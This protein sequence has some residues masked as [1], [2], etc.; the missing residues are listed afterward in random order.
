MLGAAAK[1]AKTALLE[2]PS[3]VTVAKAV[4]TEA[5]LQGMREAHLR[6]SVALAQTLHWL[7]TQVPTRR[8][9]TCTETLAG[10]LID[11]QFTSRMMH[12]AAVQRLC[13]DCEY[14]NVKSDPGAAV[15]PMLCRTELWPHP[16]WPR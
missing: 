4:K 2:R 16:C 15:S 5:E 7:E 1:V 10:R 9:G 13:A 8:V 12:M 6:D 14:Q 3:P 11:H